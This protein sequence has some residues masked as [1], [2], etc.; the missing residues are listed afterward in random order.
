MEDQSPRIGLCAGTYHARRV[1][2]TVLVFADGVHRSTG[3]HTFWVH[4]APDRA[5]T[6]LSLWHICPTGPALQVLTP[7]SVCTSIQTL[8]DVRSVTVRDV[9]GVHVIQVV[10]AGELVAHGA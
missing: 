4:D 7:F 9:S 2:G 6:D 10:E 3:Y 1:P 5:P 8:Q